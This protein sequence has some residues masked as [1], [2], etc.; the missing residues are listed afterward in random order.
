MDLLNFRETELR[1]MQIMKMKTI[2]SLILLSSIPTM[3][4]AAIYKCED[5]NRKLSYQSQPCDAS[6]RTTVIES[7]EKSTQRAARAAAKAAVLQ[8]IIS[9]E[10]S[11][12]WANPSN[13]RLKARLSKSGTFEMIDATGEKIA[14]Q[15]HASV[16]GTYIVDRTAYG[17]I[18]M[19]YDVL[20]DTLYL[21]QP[22]NPSQFV[23]YERR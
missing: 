2:I 12:L 18:K 15:W 21:T 9:K 11:G 14:T 6:E 3:S 13:Y 1:G 22:G 7:E 4:M 19:K 17:V 5:E 20:S 10:P 8:A 23:T 16:D